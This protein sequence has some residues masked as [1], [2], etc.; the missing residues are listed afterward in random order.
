MC[1]VCLP[2]QVLN[3]SKITAIK[4]RTILHSEIQGTV[5]WREGERMYFQVFFATY[6][7]WVCK[8]CTESPCPASPGFSLNYSCL[9]VFY[10]VSHWH[11]ILLKLQMIFCL[12]YIIANLS[13]AHIH[14]Y[15]KLLF[16][17]SWDFLFFL[18][19]VIWAP[20]IWYGIHFFWTMSEASMTAPQRTANAN[21]WLRYC[22]FW[23]KLYKN[24]IEQYR[25]N[26][27]YPAALNV[28]PES[29]RNT[30]ICSL[31]YFVQIVILGLW[32][33]IKFI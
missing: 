25:K 14:L 20:N 17:Q 5:T 18:T 31:N 10:T 13:T 12:P 16:Y 6:V 32:D 24:Y 7:P 15:Y 26:C 21:A 9:N 3:L 22:Y 28:S 1:Y 27:S 23:K 30:L 4:T 29:C 19:G 2:P 33:C 8:T 11:I